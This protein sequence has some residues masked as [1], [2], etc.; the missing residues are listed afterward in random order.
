MENQVSRRILGFFLAFIVMAVILVIRLVYLV[1]GSGLAQAGQAQSTQTLRVAANRGMIYDRKLRPLVNQQ[2]L[3]RAA[4]MPVEQAVQAAVRQL[5]DRS[6]SIVDLARERKPFLLEFP[7]PYV[8]AKGINVFEVYKRYTDQPFAPHI[9]GYTDGAGVHGVSGIER[10]YDDFLTHR[11]AV[12][13]VSYQ[14]DVTGSAVDG[15]SPTV[16]KSRYDVREGV[17]LTLDSDIQQIIRE[18]CEE[19]IYHK[20]SE[21]LAEDPARRKAMEYG[22]ALV[23]E[24]DTGNL[25]GCASYPEF[26]QNDVAGSLEAEGS[27]FINRCFSAYNVGSPFKLTVAAAALENGIS[28]YHTYTCKGYEDIEGQIFYCN[29]LAGHGNINMSEAVQESCN[30]YFIHL[31]KL[32]GP[33]NVMRMVQ[34]MG[35][36]SGDTLAE[37]MTSVSGTLPEISQLHM[38]PAEAANLS[39]GQ[40][41]LLATP[42]QLAKMVALI[43]NGG[44]SVTP[45]LVEGFTDETGTRIASYE[46]KYASNPVIS[47]RTAATL[48]EFM[49]GVVEEGSGIYAKPEAGGAGGKTGSAQ[50]GIYVISDDEST[51]D[52][53][54]VHAWFTGFFPARSPKYAIVVFAEEGESGAKAAAPVFKLIADG[55]AE[56]EG[57]EPEKEE[58]KEYPVEL[59][60]NKEPPTN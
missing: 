58:G 2:R 32:L 38:M 3:F 36:G 24:V 12:I 55:L 33:D 21:E 7:T 23:M 48:Q 53:E 44:N 19:A 35:F 1:Q 25:L 28:R 60:E 37:G 47:Q 16:N 10:A 30:T 15:V 43:A 14:A 46:P 17:V 22:G 20:N 29:N 42:L 59:G 50:T 6:A 11:E 57:I 26:S 8:Y 40:G 51:E 31:M 39:F 34:S 54:I 52:E 18:A 56:L 13:E 41:K 49:I 5:P 4:V 9:I 45:R 27:P